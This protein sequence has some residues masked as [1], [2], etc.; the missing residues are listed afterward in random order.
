MAGML[1]TLSVYIALLSLEAIGF[2]HV[3][4]FGSPLQSIGHERLRPLRT[5]FSMIL[6]G[7]FA[8]VSLPGICSTARLLFRA[9]ERR[10][11]RTRSGGRSLQVSCSA[12]IGIGGSS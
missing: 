8:P 3:C 1:L 10:G 6:W 4:N 7:A 11:M 9:R 5:V 2:D 12:F